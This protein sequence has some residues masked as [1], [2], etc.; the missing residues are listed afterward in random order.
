MLRLAACVLA[1][2]LL[3]GCAAIR[4]PLELRT[5]Q[6][7][8][9]R[10]VWMLKMVGQ[11][12]REPNFDERRHFDDEMEVRISDY[13][14]A[15]PEDANLLTVSTFRF[16]RQ[17]AVG[18]NKEQVLI[19]LGP[20][21]AVTTDAGEMEKLARKFWPELKGNVTETW[22]YPIGWFLYFTGQRLADIT[23]YVEG[24]GGGPD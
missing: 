9:A 4:P 12:G 13:L 11:L 1:A 3:G 16:Y 24:A 6:G 7:P 21:A 18:M 5:T 19:L 22:V 20:P 8:T 17:V 10:D 23:R 15:H 14:R 2:L